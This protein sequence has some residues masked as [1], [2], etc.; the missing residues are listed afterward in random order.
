V[1]GGAGDASDG[2]GSGTGTAAG[3]GASDAPSVDGA[4]DEVAAGRAGALLAAGGGSSEWR[5]PEPTSYP[6]DVAGSSPWPLL[7]LTLAL[8]VPVAVSAYTKRS[9]EP[10]A[11]PG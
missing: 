9:R 11:T 4:S 3:D 1:S 8:G 6:F 7:L 2:D 10:D 5:R